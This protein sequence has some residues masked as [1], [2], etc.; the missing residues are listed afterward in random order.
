MCG[1]TPTETHC[2]D[3]SP[4]RRLTGIPA[5]G[6]PPPSPRQDP[7]RSTCRIP[8]GRCPPA[9]GPPLQWSA[10]GCCATAPEVP[11]GAPVWSSGTVVLAG[12]SAPHCGVRVALGGRPDMRA[13]LGIHPEV[14]LVVVAKD[15][16]AR[17]DVHAVRVTKDSVRPGG[18]GSPRSR[19]AWCC[20]CRTRIGPSR[21]SV[22]GA[23]CPPTWP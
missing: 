4:F 15:P 22:P 6:P 14:V 2:R 18:P 8:E 1:E 21:S 5:A 16:A 20:R 11:L 10:G 13:A 3:P 19:R 9:R 7:C 23:S 12:G 17:P